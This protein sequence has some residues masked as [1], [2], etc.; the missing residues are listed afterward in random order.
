MK[1]PSCSCVFFCGWL[2]YFTNNCRK[3]YPSILVH[4]PSSCGMLFP[5]DDFKIKGATCLH[6][7]MT[8][9]RVFI[10]L[11]ILALFIVFLSSLRLIWME[12]FQPSTEPSIKQGELDLRDWD[13]SQDDVFLLDGEWE[14]YPSQFLMEENGAPAQSEFIEVPD[15]WDT[16]DESP[17]G[18]A[19]YRLR[20]YVDPDQDMN[21]SIHVPSIRSSS[22]IYVNGRLL[23]T[24]GEV[25]T[26]KGEQT[27]ENL[28]FVST[29]AAD[30]DGVI[31]LVVQ[32]ANFTDI[33]SS[34]IIRSIKF[35][36]QPAVN[37]ETTFSI[38]MQ[39]FTAV[40]FLIHA[41]YAF[42]LYIMGNRE[43]R[44]L[45]FS[46][47]SFCI[48]LAHAL[49]TDDKLFHQLIYMGYDWD[50]KLAN[51]AYLI[52]GFALLESTIHRNL[53][54][55]RKVYPVFTVI[56]LATAG[57]IIFLNPSQMMP[58]FPL[59]NGLVA[60]AGLVAIVAVWKEFSQNKRGNF[61]LILSVVALLHQIV[62][63][64]IWRENGIS[65]I[66]YPFDLII[67]VGCF[68][69]LWFK[70]YFNMHVETKELAAKL[71]RT[72]EQKDEFLADTSHEFKTPLH[73]M[74]N[75][76][77]SVLNRESA[78]MEERSIRE[79]NT[80]LSVGRR[81]SVLLNDLLDVQGLQ[82]DGLKLQKKGIRLQPIV[83]GILDMMQYHIQAKDLHMVN[84]IPDDFPL[85]YA[86]ENR[87]T[88]IMLNL[89]HNAIKYTNEGEILIKA[90]IQNGKAHITVQDT[91]VG[92]DKE[93]LERLFEPYER[94]ED[95]AILM[96]S[97]LGLGLSISQKLVELH[98]GTMEVSSTPGK[99][100]AFTFSLQL[101][102][103]DATEEKVGGTDEREEAPQ[104]LWKDQESAFNEVE[105]AAAME[106]SILKKR[107][108]Y[109]SSVLIVDD[110]P[111]NLQVLEAMLPAE[112]YEITAVTNGKEALDLLD[113]KEWDL[114]ISDVM[115]PNMSGYELTQRIRE[116]FSITELPVLLL[117]ARNHPEAI[118]SGFLS[119]AND[120]VTKPVNQL[121]LRV[122][123]EAL[124]TIKHVVKEQLQF[125]AAWLRAQIK[126]HFLFNT[127]NSII[128]L[129]EIDLDKMRKMLDELSKLLMHKFQFKETDDLIPI[130]EELSA[131]RSY[132]YIEQVRFQDRLD[133]VWETEP[134][135]G[136]QIP[137]LSIQ[138]LVE[139]AIH[140]GLMKQIEGGKLA[141]R[142]A[143]NP[144]HATITIEDNGVGIEADRLQRMKQ[145]EDHHNF[146]VGLLNIDRRLKRHFGTGLT[147]E[148]VQ[149][150]GTT[151]SFTVDR[152]TG[153][154]PLSSS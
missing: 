58:F 34:G 92:I 113:T 142:I 47:L 52:G 117:T 148:S 65:L 144:T 55:W 8:K 54:Y 143:T 42:I 38:S 4:T 125:E 137:H 19:S 122:R 102:S 60:V 132:L 96:E 57:S 123:I 93:L 89:I 27:A 140:H 46:L 2:S 36:S 63:L 23:V 53:P 15:G 51:L 91:G 106:Q 45:Y 28:P 114:V 3:N 84:Q 151:L 62:W 79:M 153:H 145:K 14:L 141:I 18:Y 131:V 100:S 10:L 37:E 20:I 12:A 116:R 86:D 68:G 110:D 9:K 35:G 121:E 81:M 25:A 136:I 74:L 1:T 50:F 72:N 80:V 29:F 32:A 104:A 112:N 11:S 97:G 99:G 101:A 5:E 111:V 21:Y 98:G 146:G 95:N 108:S 124:T 76:S 77:E 82:E 26:T 138:P 40:I 67:A 41:V 7:M 88:Q 130:E 127:L 17:F 120:Y 56:L 6:K 152:K 49:T 115:M 134:C 119:G 85:L 69:A 48:T 147:V 150:E 39:V 87:V 107:K 78:G 128:A 149:G 13:A 59:Y 126:P 33:R 118:R 139:N 75:L 90:S 133:V 44:L 70:N 66:H 43:K 30:E 154:S 22:E 73:G 129:S 24:S 94:D 31:D 61:L 64:S 71:Q 109:H 103:P 83:T 105:M 16:G 135:E